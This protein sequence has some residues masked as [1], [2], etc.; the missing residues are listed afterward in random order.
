MHQSPVI[1]R[2]TIWPV[3][4]AA[5]LALA[6]AVGL[7]AVVLHPPAEDLQALAL[8]LSL[9]GLLSLAVGGLAARLGWR[10]RWGGVR[11][12]II[13]AIALGVLVALANIAVTAALMFLSPHDLALL[14]LLLGFALVLSLIAGAVVL[15]PAQPLACSP[16]SLRARVGTGSHTRGD[17]PRQDRKPATVNLTFTNRDIARN[18]SMPRCRT[19][20][21]VATSVASSTPVAAL[22]QGRVLPDPVRPSF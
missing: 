11:L 6:L 18:L 14:G 3:A 8:S 12:K 19:P 21:V 20:A 13:L 15:A 2:S 4:L 9:S 1:S 10:L 17:S 7:A 22:I 5:G 16:A